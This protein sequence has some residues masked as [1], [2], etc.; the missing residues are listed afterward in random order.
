MFEKIKYR[1]I[2]YVVACFVLGIKGM[3]QEQSLRFDHISVEDGLSQTSIEAIVQDKYGFLWI[4]T[5]D[6]LNRFPDKY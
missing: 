4:G 3:A 1:L 5:Q 6:G 2:L